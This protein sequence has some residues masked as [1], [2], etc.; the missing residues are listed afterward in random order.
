MI[1]NGSDYYL[2]PSNGQF[3]LL[4]NPPIY[5][6][7]YWAEWSQPSG[8][9]RLGA[10]LVKLGYKPLLIDCMESNTDRKVPMRRRGKSPRIIGNTTS[11]EY[12]YGLD[13]LEFKKRLE[14]LPDYP[15][16]VFIS[17]GMT[18]WWVSTYDVINILRLQFPK[19]EIVIGGIYPTLCPEHAQEHLGDDITI[20][21]G[22]IPDVSNLFPELSLYQNPPNYAIINTSR[23]CPFNCDYCA[24]R[25]INGVGV[26]Q[27]SPDE[28]FEEITRDINLGIR[29]FAIYEDLLLYKADTHLRVLLSKIIDSKMRLHFFSPEGIDPRMLN[30]DLLNDMKKAG[31]RK[32]HLGFENVYSEVRHDWNRINYLTNETF[33]NAVEM[34]I[35]AGFKLRST[36]INAFVLYGVPN[37]RIEDVVDTILYVSHIVGS[38]I[39]ML[40]SPVPGSEFFKRISKY[41]PEDK[42]ALEDL[43]GKFIPFAE[44]NGY[45]ASDY[46]DLLRLM[47]VLNHGVRGKSLDL[48]EDNLTNGFVRDRLPLLSKNL[49]GLR[50]GVRI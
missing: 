6:I 9:L 46:V 45:K 17:S 38:I 15:T 36:E 27:R 48:L 13:L 28:V 24:Q 22:E 30:Q 50:K 1:I 3:V 20:V 37:E 35:N 40:F 8:L 49:T 39:P 47:F 26:R 33:E 23:G 5:D 21:S 10:L 34:C 19:S 44:Y 2:P 31:W 12:I 29:E 41:L 7:Q 42:L 32:I 16:K 25:A 4:I 43:N 11:W 14:S 18:Y